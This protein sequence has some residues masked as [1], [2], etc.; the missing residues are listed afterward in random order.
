MTIKARIKTATLE[1]EYEGAVEFFK[2]EFLEIIGTLKDQTGTGQP[3]HSS[4]TRVIDSGAPAPSGSSGTTR[5]LAARLGVKTGPD[6]LMA[7]A[8]RLHLVEDRASF[9]RQDLLEEIKT[10]SGYYKANMGKNLSQNLKTLIK[11]GKLIELANEVYTVSAD[12]RTEL[13]QRLG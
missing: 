10:A 1:V 2:N 12:A 11:D 3:S 7:A 6:L 5:S 13:E 8:G 4:A 9:K